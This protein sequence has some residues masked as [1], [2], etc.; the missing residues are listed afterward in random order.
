[1]M[2]LSPHSIN[3]L[4]QQLGLPATDSD[5]ESFFARHQLA[6]GTRLV[7]ADFWT[8]AQAAFLN[9]ALEEDAEWTEVVDQLDA[10]LR[11]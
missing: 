1:M 5:V 7:K 2:D 11:H 8:E 4:F 3:T 9:E 10:R 6:P